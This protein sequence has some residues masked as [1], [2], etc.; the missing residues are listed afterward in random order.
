MQSVTFIKNGVDKKDVIARI[1]NVTE[2]EYKSIIEKVKEGLKNDD[3]NVTFEKGNILTKRDIEKN[4]GRDMDLINAYVK[5][6]V[7]FNIRKT[8]L[9]LSLFSTFLSLIFQ[10]GGDITIYKVFIYIAIM[11]IA[12]TGVLIFGDFLKDSFKNTLKRKE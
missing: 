12:T 2:D 10:V 6:E 4:I 1:D 3:L 9:I 11:L 5:N 7:K 8:L